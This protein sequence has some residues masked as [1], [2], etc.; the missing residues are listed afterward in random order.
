MTT[1]FLI[2]DGYNLLH[3][4]GLARATYGPGQLRRKR[5]ELLARLSRRMSAEE[6]R[7]CT[8]VFDAVDAPPNASRRF[9]HYEMVVQF[10]EPGH[11]ADEVIETLIAQH[12][13]PR[14]L[15]VVSSDHRLQKAIQRRRGT[16]IDSDIFLKKLESAQ[17]QIGPAGA[18]PLDASAGSEAEFW[19]QEFQNVDPGSLSK[20]LDGED[21]K[22]KSGWE[23]QIDELQERLQ[24]PDD[25]DAWLNEK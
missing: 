13:V 1:P 19:A 12:S 5:M 7:R 25:L 15:T 16:A 14:N 24:N 4:A 22:A 21:P 10:A 20:Q 8:V 2:I 23:R 17:R 3:E 6:R 9:K 18:L 11:E